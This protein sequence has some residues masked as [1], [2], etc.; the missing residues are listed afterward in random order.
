MYIKINKHDFCVKSQK[1][2]N[3]V[4]FVRWFSILYLLIIISITNLAYNV[5]WYAKSKERGFLS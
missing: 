1:M 4:I 3:D 5:E 2:N